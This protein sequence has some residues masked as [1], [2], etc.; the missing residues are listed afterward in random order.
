MTRFTSLFGKSLLALL[1][2]GGAALPTSMQAQDDAITVSVPFPFTV[3]TQ[4]IAPGTYRFRLV[5]SQFLLSVTNVKT[6]HE[7]LFAVHPDRQR[8][9]QVRGGLTFGNSAGRSI[10]NEVHFPGTDT[11]SEVIER[12]ASRLEAKRSTPQNSVAVAKR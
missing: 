1:I 12:R 3:G 11:F 4:S 5:S 7:E 8:S 2:A 6:G 10:L 9:V